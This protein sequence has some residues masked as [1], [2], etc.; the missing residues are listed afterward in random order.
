M[1]R[2]LIQQLFAVSMIGGCLLLSGC[3][4]AP[5][6]PAGTSAPSAPPVSSETPETGEDT[7]LSAEA[8]SE[9]SQSATASSSAA[10]QSGAATSDGSQ[11]VGTKAIT[12]TVINMCGADIGMFSVIDPST[13]EQVN[14]EALA[15]EESLSLNADWPVDVAELQW[16]VY[17]LEGELYMEGRTDI[18]E[19]EAAATLL[20]MGEG[21]IENVETL[22]Q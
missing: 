14:L 2:N 15:D 4:K 18:S 7:A 21:S 5:D 20:L 10:S 1:K 19:A 12:L 9:A 3:G 17:N 6:T 13:G 16:A 11:A 8:A 22:F